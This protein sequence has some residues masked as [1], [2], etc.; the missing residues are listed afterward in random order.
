MTSEKLTKFGIKV[1]KYRVELGETLYQ[2]AKT[3]GVSPSY[4]SGV[5]TGR[6]RASEEL[7]EQLIKHLE[8]D[9]VNAL[10][11]KK[12]A[13]ETGPELRIPLKGKGNEARYVAAMFARRFSSGEFSELKEALESI[14]NEGYGENE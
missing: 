1:R 8:L 14:N 6:K 5:E 2:M 7:V 12:A 3:L 4:L 11:L 9:M 13:A 10:E